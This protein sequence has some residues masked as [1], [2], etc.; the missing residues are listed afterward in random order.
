VRE[1]LGNYVKQVKDWHND[2]CGNEQATKQSLIAPLFTMLGYNTSDPRECKP[3]CRADFGRGEK[4]ATPVDWAFLI[5]GALAFFV[6][7]KEGGAKIAKYPEQLG[8]YFAKEPGVKGVKLGILTNGAEWQ[9]YTDLRNDNVMDTEPFFTWNVLKDDPAFAVELLTILQ[10]AEFS[11]QRIRTFAEKKHHQ[12]LL[13]GILNRLLAPSPEFVRLAIGTVINDAGDTILS[14]KITEKVIDQWKPILADAIHEWAK[15]HDL[16]IALQPIEKADRSGTRKTLRQDLRARPKASQGIIVL[17]DLIDFGILT[18]PL[19]LFRRYKGNRL[20]ARLLADGTV[21]FQEH[22]Y[23]TCSAAAE[24]ARKSVTGVRQ[25]TNGWTFW[26]YQGAN[27]KTLTLSEA[28][29]QLA[30][31]RSKF[32]GDEEEGRAIAKNL[33]GQPEYREERQKA[34]RYA[35]RKRFWQR[36]L[37]RAAPKTSLHKNISAGDCN[38]IGAGSGIRGLHFNY[39]IRK[40][41]GTAE[42]Y[43]D[44]GVEEEN[45]QVLGALKAHQAEIEKAFGGPLSWQPLEGKRACRIAYMTTAGGWRS[46]EAKWPAIQDA[47]IDAMVRLENALSPHLAKLRAQA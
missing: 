44:R 8:M 15:Q 26:Q 18:A 25:N 31:S 28:R 36:L 38:W 32:V 40:Q 37:D 13:V 11:P 39:V 46:D 42:L 14:G 21:E 29:K 16:T 41:G 43:I 9:F 22:G 7:A 33:R 3:E 19:N 4:A 10:K 34:K 24:A 17:A 1:Q 23:D 12:S 2:C 47:M 27:G 45:K 20:E 35:I 30:K 6:E 5:N